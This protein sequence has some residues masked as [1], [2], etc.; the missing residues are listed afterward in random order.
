MATLTEMRSGLAETIQNGVESEIF[1]YPTVPEVAQLP[2]IVVL[3]D[4]ADFAKAFKR[5]LDEWTFS[6]YVLVSRS[7]AGVNQEQLDAF[8][9][10]AGPDSV[11]Q[12]LYSDPT[13]GLV[14]TDAFVSGIEAY[15][16]E[17]KTAK[18]THMGAVIKVVVRTDGA[19]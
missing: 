1:S 13:I 14:D 6:V 9:T 7:I 5:G 10:G 17:F 2:A 18:V 16:G 3:P 12:A 15:G 8:V 19:S 4:K 11:R